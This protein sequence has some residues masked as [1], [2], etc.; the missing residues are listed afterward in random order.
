MVQLEIRV[1]HL[2]SLWENNVSRK[3]LANL[4]E[5]YGTKRSAEEIA[6]EVRGNNFHS[7]GG[8]GGEVIVVK[9]IKD[10]EN[11]KKFWETDGKWNLA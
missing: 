7:I 4:N 6:R 1:C 5:T 9:P 10:R 2:N 8:Y 11:S 3:F